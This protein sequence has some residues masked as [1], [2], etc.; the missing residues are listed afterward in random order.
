MII[1]KIIK[2]LIVIIT[3]L[4][5]NILIFINASNAISLREYKLKA[6][7]GSITLLKYKGEAITSFYVGYEGKIYNYPAYCLDKTKEFVTDKLSYSVT[8]KDEISDAMLWRYIV[9]GYPYKTSS[10]LDC[11]GR[12]EAYIATQQA[13]YCYLYGQKIEDYEPIGEAGKRTLQA[14]KNII[15]NAQSSQET[16]ASQAVKINKIDLE[17]KQDSIDKNFVSKTYEVKSSLPIESY[18][19]K[20]QKLNGEIITDFI[21]TDENNKEKKQFKQN[22]KFKILLPIKEMKK[23][24]KFNIIVQTIVKAKPVIY[25][26]PN[27]ILYQDFAI[28]ATETEEFVSETIDEPYPENN[29]SIKII[30]QDKETEEKI[31]GVQFEILDSNKKVLYENLK[32]N[33]NGE[34]NINGLIPGTYYIRETKA[35]EGY[36]LSQKLVEVTAKL[37]QSIEILFYNLKDDVPKIKVNEKEVITYTPEKS[38]PKEITKITQIKKLPVTGM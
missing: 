18:D 28:P 26:I 16:P 13:I 37:N 32:T 5:F 8:E 22:E 1:K 30:K 24:E 2:I 6:M 14:M 33:E 36:I 7:G 20:I 21:I 29:T 17:F 23:G 15:K 11:A 19:V 31:E 10:E 9:N 35:K 12:D 25:A 4:L 3:I 27:D 38:E 34:I